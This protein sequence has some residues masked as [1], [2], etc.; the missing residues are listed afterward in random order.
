MASA[1]DSQLRPIDAG[2][3]SVASQWFA[4]YAAGGNWFWPH[5]G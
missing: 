4:D 5:I 2:Q 1:T 3:F